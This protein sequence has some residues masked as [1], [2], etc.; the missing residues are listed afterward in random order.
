MRRDREVVKAL[1]LIMLTESDRGSSKAFHDF[2]MNERILLE[3]IPP[4]PHV[5]TDI[6]TD[7]KR[8]VPTRSSWFCLY[9]ITHFYCLK[10]FL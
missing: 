7:D 10:L 8:T 4:Q 1:I 2:S 3:A 9:A 6:T 5:T